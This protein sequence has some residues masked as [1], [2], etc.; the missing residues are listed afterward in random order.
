L[1]VKPHTLLVQMATPFIGLVQSLAMQQPDDG[2]H[3][4]PQRL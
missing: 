4:L 3:A 1:Q 2:M